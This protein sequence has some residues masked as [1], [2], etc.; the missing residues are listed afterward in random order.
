VTDWRASPCWV[1]LLLLYGVVA[2]GAED[3]APT[4]DQAK[5]MQAA[6]LA[7]A[8][9]YEFFADAGQTRKLVLA[10]RPILHWSTS[11]DWSGDLF[12][13]TDRG[14]PEI[15]GCIL[16]GP[17]DG[18]GRPFFHELHSLSARRAATQT[19]QD[20]RTWA[21]EAAGVVFSPIEGA[22]IPAA[23]EK[24][25]LTQMRSL[26]REFTTC[27]LHY[28][29]EWELRLLPQPV[30]RYQRPMEDAPKEW[31]DGAIFASVLTMGTDAEVLLVLEARPQDGEVRWQFAPVRMTTRPAWMRRGDREIWRVDA[32][33]EKGGVVAHPYTT[34][35]TGRKT[36]DQ[37]REPASPSP[38]PVPGQNP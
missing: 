13:W 1:G 29:S 8:K 18:G 3:L 4:G 33:S 34:F 21:P 7:D 22:P 38:E 36:N 6:Y 12:V 11:D 35:P 28:D 30:F 26:A 31:L 27:V 24:S 15:V 20:G 19:F 16:S 32:H 2:A 9:D 14:R 23:D 25:R 17:D 5:A 37:A 10:S